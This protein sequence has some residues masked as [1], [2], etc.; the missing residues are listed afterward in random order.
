MRM[1]DDLTDSGD[2]RV[3]FDLGLSTRLLKR[4]TWNLSLSDRYLS[5]PVPGRKTNDF[6]YTTG[7]GLTF[8]K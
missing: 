6:L 5:D 3:N 4:I 1:F 7:V 8:G 2:Y